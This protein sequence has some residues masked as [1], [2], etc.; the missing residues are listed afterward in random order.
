MSEPELF[1]RLQIA[2]LLYGLTV[3]GILALLFWWRFRTP[4][5]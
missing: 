2:T 1:L 3:F 5:K 4:R